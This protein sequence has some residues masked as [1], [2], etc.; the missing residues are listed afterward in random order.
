MDRLPADTWSAFIKDW[1][2]EVPDTSTAYQYYL[3]ALARMNK[4]KEVRQLIREWVDLE[5]KRERLE[6][7]GRKKADGA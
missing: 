1:V 2:A 6:R 7:S 4:V 3:V 5:L